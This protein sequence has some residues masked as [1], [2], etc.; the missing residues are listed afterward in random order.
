MHVFAICGIFCLILFNKNAL[1]Y[2]ME[3]SARRIRFEKVA[4]KRVNR[5]L[6]TLTNLSK[7]A[8][9]NNYEYSDSDIRKMFKVLKEKLSDVE[10]DFSGELNKDRKDEFKF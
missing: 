2:T 6:M 10:K 1:I 8:S 9:K 4:G 7:C 3:Q 5:I